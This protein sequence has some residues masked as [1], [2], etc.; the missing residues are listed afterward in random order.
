MKKNELEILNGLFNKDNLGK[1]VDKILFYLQI[2][3]ENFGY[4]SFEHMSY[5]GEY[6]D[7]HNSQI[8]SVSSFYKFFN[9]DVGAAK[10]T[11]RICQ[12]ISCDL[13][14]K[15]RIIKGFENELGISIG[16]STE[17]REFKLSYCNCLGMCDRGPA[18]LINDILISKVS[19]NMI[20]KI[21]DACKRNKLTELFSENI[22]SKVYYEDRLIKNDEIG[23]ALNEAFKSSGNE[24]IETLKRVNLRGRGGAGF[25]TGKK[26]ELA[27]GQI[28]EKKYIVCN[29]DEGEPGTFKDRYLLHKHCG[30]IIEGMIIAGYAVG[31]S[32]GF[33]YIRTEYSYLL[34]TIN[35]TI[36]DYTEKGFINK[37]LFDKNFEF[38]ITVRLGMGAYICGEETALIESL[39]GK[40]GE[41]RNRPP[42]PIDTGYLDCPTVVN[43]VET[44]Y[45]VSMIFELGNEY[46][47]KFGTDESRGLKLFSISGDLK[48]EGIYVIPYGT[49]LSELVKLCSAVDIG[50]I[51]VGGAQGT[52][53]KKEEFSN[54]LAFEALQSG[55][56]IIL[57]NKNRDLLDVLQNFLEFFVDESCGQCTP[58]RLGIPELLKG[59][60]SM[61]NGRLPISKL[62]KLIELAYTIKITSKCGLGT[63]SINGFLSV[64]ENF[65]EEILGRVQEG[66]TNGNF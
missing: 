42:Y 30:K 46:F 50:A 39:E 53:V 5:L 49:T 59:I 54:C 8:E 43:N 36:K 62:N 9:V 55:G 61:K 65:K 15:D 14:N 31:A 2:I 58:C 32:Q 45:D 4:L 64:V 24:I 10:Y 28:S 44:F 38:N 51:V 23:L 6:L 1:D 41:P 11:I 56:S 48:N 16:Q 19:P 21:I 66:D 35:K 37:N 12:T 17:N 18:I 40:R 20:P 63:G 22:I 52:I 33:L 47:N 57:I 3:Q 13:K 34:P 25:P 27:K 7:V 29:G 26:W 60:K